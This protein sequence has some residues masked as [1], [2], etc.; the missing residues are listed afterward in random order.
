MRFGFPVA[1]KILILT[2]SVMF[3]LFVC[4]C[5]IFHTLDRP[6]VVLLRLVSRKIHRDESF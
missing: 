4:G 5:L 1:R 2:S 3:C 6:M